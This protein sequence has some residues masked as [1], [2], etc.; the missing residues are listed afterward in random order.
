MLQQQLD[1]KEKLQ[2]EIQQLHGKFMAVMEH[3]DSESKRKIEELG[4]KL[5]DKYDE[6]EAME[7]LNQTLVIKDRNSNNELQNAR[8]EMIA[9]FQDLSVGRAKIGI[10]R[11]GELDM[12]AFG[13]PLDLASELCAKLEAEIKDPNWHPFRVVHVDGKEMEVLWEADGKLQKLKEEHGEEIYALVTKALAEINGYNP[14][15]RFPVAELWNYK[16]GRKATL[17]EA[18]HDVMKQLQP[19]RLTRESVDPFVRLGSSG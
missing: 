7:S 1:A 15:G 2:L 10:K 9:G 8:K 3:E 14:S 17:K 18:V 11:M 19:C 4:E 16:E 5:Q 12:N 6:T 13:M